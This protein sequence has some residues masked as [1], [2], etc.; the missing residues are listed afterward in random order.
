MTLS[1]PHP[2][3]HLEYCGTSAREAVELWLNATGAA[4]DV[5]K[6]VE[7]ELAAFRKSGR[8]RWPRV[9]GSR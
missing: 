2:L 8:A 9:P 6:L 7:D 3:Y 1:R 5:I 4:M